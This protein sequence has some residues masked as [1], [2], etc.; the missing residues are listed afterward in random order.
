[1]PVDG[2]ALLEPYREFEAPGVAFDQPRPGVLRLR[3]ARPERWNAIPQRVHDALPTLFARIA[4]DRGVAAFMLA[5]EGRVFSSGGDV[6]EGMRPRDVGEL[7]DL[8]WIAVRTITRLLELPQPSFCVVNGPA[9]GFAASL[10]LNF[11]FIVAADTAT[12]ADSH[13]AFGAAPADGLVLIATRTLGPALARELLFGGRKLTAR[14]AEHHGLVN[15]V[16]APADLEDE[17]LALVDRVLA[18]APLAVRTAKA[19]VNAP[20]RAEAEELLT[21]AVAAE[22]LTLASADFRHAVDGFM[23]HR[24]FAQDWQGR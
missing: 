2:D 18:L 14:E 15:R 10:A 23:E 9:I 4:D 21:G 20:L 13:A 3:L 17:A 12:F 7:V 24:R 5:G 22:M 11:D 8:Q 19:F 1:M 6:D 16:V